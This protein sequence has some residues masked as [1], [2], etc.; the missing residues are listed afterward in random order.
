MSESNRLKDSDVTD[1]DFSMSRIDAQDETMSRVPK[2]EE[3]SSDESKQSHAKEEV[4]IHGIL[5]D[6]MY[7]KEESKQDEMEPRM[8]VPPVDQ[9][10][11][12]DIGVEQGQTASTFSG[13]S[14]SY[15]AV[16]QDSKS[17]Q[18]IDWVPR[19]RREPKIREGVFVRVKSYRYGDKLLSQKDLF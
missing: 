8:L 10:Q 14:H 3:E 5:I 4:E 11:Y 7:P 17:Q 1:P 19:K 13:F 12:S 6:K 15:G 9:S 2:V 16:S 18:K